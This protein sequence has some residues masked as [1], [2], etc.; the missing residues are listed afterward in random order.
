MIRFAFDRQ[1]TNRANLEHLNLY[2]QVNL[3]LATL[4]G[5]SIGITAGHMFVVNKDTVLRVSI[6]LCTT[7]HLH[8]PFI[9]ALSVYMHTIH[10]LLGRKSFFYPEIVPNSTF[11][12]F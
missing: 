12:F 5:T 9:S 8:C 3:F 4:M 11:F 2:F 1:E 10:D 6:V 7:L